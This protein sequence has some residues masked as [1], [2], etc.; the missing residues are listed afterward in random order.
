VEV[1]GGHLEHPPL[2]QPERGDLEDDRQGLDHVQ[3]AEHGQQQ[4]GVGEQGQGGQGAAKGQRAGV[5]HE[6]PG[7]GAFHHR[8]PAVAPIMAAATMAR[9]WGDS[10]AGNE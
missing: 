7:R 4:L 6:D 10:P 3:P 8:N 2:E 1:D 5:A 9:S